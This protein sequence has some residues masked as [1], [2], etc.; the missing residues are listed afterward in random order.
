MKAHSHYIMTL[1]GNGPSAYGQNIATCVV[2]S[3][4]HITDMI[5]HKEASAGEVWRNILICRCLSV[6]NRLVGVVEYS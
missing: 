4:M 5:H 1:T 2:M 6:T 3:M